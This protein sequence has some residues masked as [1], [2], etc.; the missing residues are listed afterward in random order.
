MAGCDDKDAITLNLRQCVFLCQRNFVFCFWKLWKSNKS[1]KRQW[2]AKQ[3]EIIY[4]ES[5]D[6]NVEMFREISSKYFD[7][8]T[9]LLSH[10]KNT[11]LYVARSNT[12]MVVHKME[13]NVSVLDW[14]RQFEVCDW[15]SNI[16]LSIV[17]LWNFESFFFRC[18][19]GVVLSGF[20]DFKKIF[21]AII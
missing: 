1:V 2:L 18:G 3:Y 15:N 12:T 17:W 14:M 13:T 11:L 21:S 8:N 10:E 5:V 16:S 4:L 7:T 9:F 20:E 6:W 19:V